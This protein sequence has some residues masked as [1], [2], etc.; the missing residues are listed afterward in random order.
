MTVN[1]SFFNIDVVAAYYLAVFA[2]FGCYCMQ[3]AAVYCVSRISGYCACCYTGNLTVL[4]ESNLAVN[5][6]IAILHVNRCALTVNHTCSSCCTIQ[7]QFS[8]TIG[9]SVAGYVDIC[10]FC[11][12]ISIYAIFGCNSAGSFDSTIGT[13]DAY[14]LTGNITHHDIIVQVNFINLLAINSSF[15]N[16]S[17][18]AIYNL[19]VLA[20]FSCYSMQLAAVYSI[21]GISSDCTCCYAGNLAV[22]SNS[23]FAQLSAF[24]GDLAVVAV[25]IAYI[26]LTVTQCGIFIEYAI[27][28]NYVA[29]FAF[30][31]GY[32]AVFIYNQF[33]VGSIECAVAV[34]EERY[35]AVFICSTY[36]QVVFCV[37]G[38]G[39]DG[40]YTGHVAFFIDSYLTKFS[41]FRS[42][43]A[44][45]A[46]CIAYIQLTVTQCGIFIEYAIF[47]NY[48]ADFAFGCGYFAVFIYNQFAVGSI[49]CAVAVYEERY[50]AVFICSTYG[51]VVFCVQGI[52]LDGVYTGHVA[53]F[54]DSY[55]TKF[56]GIRSDLA[57]ATACI[58]YEQLAINQF[59]ITGVYAIIQ[60][61]VACGYVAVFIYNQFA[62]GC[63]ECA[64]AV[65]EERHG[66]VFICSTYGQVVF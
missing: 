56:S 14:I 3:L 8:I 33:A 24:S 35:S 61:Y 36:G 59:G 11:T 38:I 37:Q 48:V 60:N 55:L 51:Q 19:A 18:V 42:D 28:Q 25:C 40:V 31:C 12:I 29:D 65:Y 45:V 13:T 63:I 26:Q 7:C 57:V 43:L 52:G 46:V 62:V 34:Y 17:V 47:Q 15:F 30:G 44:V 66:A 39:L 2:C 21:G 1:I 50:S 16:I 4:I 58:A 27:F 41:G 49:E 10:Q 22:Y 6:G 23:Y 9:N 54:I 5:Y 53:F 64:V 20:C 32:F